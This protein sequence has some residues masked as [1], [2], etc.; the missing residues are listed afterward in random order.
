MAASLS[1]HTAKACPRTIHHW[2]FR[3]F[4][5][6]AFTTGTQSSQTFKI[7]DQELFPA[8]TPHLSVEISDS[9]ITYDHGVWKT[10]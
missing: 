4:R 1:L 2:L 10:K 9:S 8:G 5:K 6:K 7:S 3:N